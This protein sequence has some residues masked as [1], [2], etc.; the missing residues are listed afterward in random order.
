[1]IEGY[2]LRKSAYLIGNISY[3]TLFYWRHKLLSSWFQVLE[4]I[5][6]QKNE[7]TLNDLIIRESLVQNSENYDTLRLTQFTM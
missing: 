6:H 1:M 5:Q 7:V 2:S 4:S 3:V